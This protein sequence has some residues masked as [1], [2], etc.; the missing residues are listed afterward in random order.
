MSQYHML[1]GLL[2]RIA[3]TFPNTLDGA[4][5]ANLFMESSEGHH[6]GV[7]TVTDTTIILACCSDKGYRPC[8]QWY[9]IRWQDGIER[10]VWAWDVGSA[11]LIG[12]DLMER[13]SFDHGDVVAC[14]P[15]GA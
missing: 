7:L 9:R 11:K 15:E 13:E 14:Q 4:R 6:T 1:N 10:S 8:Y 5:E 12:E 3:A 2:F